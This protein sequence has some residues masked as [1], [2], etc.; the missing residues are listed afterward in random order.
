MT[1]RSI[2]GFISRCMACNRLLDTGE[3]KRTYPN[4]DELVGLCNS[5]INASKEKQYSPTFTL[6]NCSEGASPSL[7]SESHSDFYYSYFDN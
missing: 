7:H 6:E 5:C 4:S 1:N 3:Q 2:T